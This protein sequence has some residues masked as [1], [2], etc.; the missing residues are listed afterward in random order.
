MFR[1]T[2]LYWELYYFK[3]EILNYQ[4]EMEYVGCYWFHKPNGKMFDADSLKDYLRDNPLQFQKSYDDIYKAANSIVDIYDAYD[5]N[6][7]PENFNNPLK[8]ED[9]KKEYIC[10]HK[11][12]AIEVKNKKF[13]Y[14]TYIDSFVRELKSYESLSFYQIA[15]ACCRIVNIIDLFKGEEGS[16]K[17]TIR[18]PIN[19][20]PLIFKDGAFIVFKK[21]NESSN[22]PLDKKISFIFQKLKQDNRLRAT[23]FKRLSTWAL[24]NDYLDKDSYDKLFERGHFDQPSKIFTSKRLALYD[25]IM[26]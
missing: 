23:D 1:A 10:N 13:V 26:P 4:N 7:T 16:T 6:K 22:E 2:Q 17:K 14:W 3:K 24:E 8:F 15:V 25:A 21:W 12:I 19:P 11:I 20:Y 18:K 5:E 9:F